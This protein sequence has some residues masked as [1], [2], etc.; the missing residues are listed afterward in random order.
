MAKCKNC[1]MEV[2]SNVNF[3]PNCGAAVGSSK[4][5]SVIVTCGHCNGN[6]GGGSSGKG[7]GSC[8]VCGGKGKVRV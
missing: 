5:R 6:G 1:E 2:A 7:M 8:S 3:C 4:E